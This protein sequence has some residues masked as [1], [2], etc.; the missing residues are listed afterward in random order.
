MSSFP[1]LLASR[2]AFG[3]H[4]DCCRK[5]TRLTTYVISLLLFARCMASRSARQYR[6]LLAFTLVALALGDSSGIAPIGDIVIV[7]TPQEFLAA[8]ND[9]GV[10]HV[11]VQAHMNISTE[12][13][14]DPLLVAGATTKVIRVRIIRF[15]LVKHPPYPP[16]LCYNRAVPVSFSFA[17]YLIHSKD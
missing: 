3:S 7:K 11:V 14:G 9:A 1:E 10:A 2:R 13:I 5:P 16:P 17:R 15:H 12:S 8:V 6:V 4:V